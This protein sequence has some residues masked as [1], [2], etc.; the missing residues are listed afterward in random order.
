MADE[1]TSLDELLRSGELRRGDGVY[2]TDAT[3]RRINGRIS[4]ASPS[5]MEVT[6]GR[7]IWT[8]AENEVSKIECQDPVATGIWLG[9]G[10]P[11]QVPML[12][13]ASNASM[14]LNAAMPPPTRSSRH[15]APASA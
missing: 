9:I 6:D 15:W 4:D 2:F 3:G 1:A 13:A 11:W 5:I 7:D 14:A 10:L 12:C 8:L